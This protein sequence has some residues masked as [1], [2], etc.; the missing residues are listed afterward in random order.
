MRLIDADKFLKYLI[1][2]KH[3]YS[4]TCKEVKEAVEMCKVD[5]LDKIRAEI[6]QLYTV[7]TVYED[8]VAVD[9]ADVL[10]TIDKYKGDKA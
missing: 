1:F 2:S 8:V 7:D 3:I 4:L 5:V 10:R 9:K 6:E